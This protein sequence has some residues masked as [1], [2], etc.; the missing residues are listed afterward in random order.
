MADWDYIIV[1]GGSA[2]CVLANRLSEDPGTKVLLLEDD[3]LHAAA[4]LPIMREISSTSAREREFSTARLEQA[5]VSGRRWAVGD[6]ERLLVESGTTVLKFFLVISKEE[7]RRRLQARLDDPHKRWK[8]S[9]SDLVERGSWDRY[10]EVNADVLSATSTRHAPWYL[11]PADHKWY[12]NYVVART[13][14]HTLTRMDPRFPV[15]PPDLDFKKIRI[16]R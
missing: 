5:L 3:E 6:F 2:G 11:I 4:A 15:A 16:P 1:G 7:Q 12:R 13:L 9:P 8:F 14:L 10:A